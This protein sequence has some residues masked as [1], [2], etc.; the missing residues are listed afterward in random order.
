MLV[1]G[2]LSSKQEAQEIQYIA[3][4]CALENR[5]RFIARRQKIKEMLEDKKTTLNIEK[6]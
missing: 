6:N 1:I 2:L 4:I 3:K 5:V